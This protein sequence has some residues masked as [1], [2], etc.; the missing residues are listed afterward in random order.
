MAGPLPEH[1]NWKKLISE[2]LNTLPKKQNYICIALGVSFLFALIV[3][4]AFH[5]HP[6]NYHILKVPGKIDQ[7]PSHTFPG[8]YKESL[9][10][11]APA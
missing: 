8:K 9:W 4:L 11:T 7:N 10:T 6:R 2:C 5:M 1:T 3:T